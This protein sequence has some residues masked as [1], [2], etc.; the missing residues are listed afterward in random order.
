LCADETI[1][2]GEQPPDCRAWKHL[3]PS[4][5]RTLWCCGTGGTGIAA[6]IAEAYGSLI[7]DI[8][9]VADEL[10]GL[11]PEE[12]IARRSELAAEARQSGDRQLATEIGKLRRASVAAWLMNRLARLHTAQL[13]KLSDFAGRIRAAHHGLKGD[14]LR[15]LSGERQRLLGA[16]T[17]FIETD[18]S[19]AERPATDAV[20][21]QVRQTLEAAIADEDAEA[22][23]RSGRLTTALS[24]AGFGD[25]DLS[26]AV[27]LP[28]RRPAKPASRSHLRSV[29]QPQA[30]QPS[31]ADASAAEEVAAAAA[32]ET[33][34]AMAERDRLQTHHAQA[35]QRLADLEA[36][37]EHAR[38]ARAEAAKLLTVAQRRYER[39]RTKQEAAEQALR[40]GNS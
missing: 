14:E 4:V 12:F 24:Y 17:T 23:I 39:A 11:E 37:I 19:T 15:K 36:K 34:A 40:A 5:P 13:D 6:S 38:T 27:A 22:A 35:E 30:A 3:T 7:V 26:N 28:D 32:S 16:L 29:P 20:L 21:Q 10:Y 8:E 9:S 33:E 2:F 25:V 18:A 1:P 31:V